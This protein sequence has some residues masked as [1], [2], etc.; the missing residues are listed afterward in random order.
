MKKNKQNTNLKALPVL[1]V[2][3]IMGFCDIVGISSDYVQR[4]FNWS[5]AMTGFVPSMVFLWFLFLGIPV[6]NWMNT[7]GRKNTVLVSMVLTM[8]GMALPLV[9]YDSM[10]CMAAYALLG[11]GNAILQVSLN[12]LLSN[13]IT[14]KKLITSS[15]TAGQVIKAVSSLV[16][17]EIVLLAVHYWGIDKWYYCF[18]ILGFMT[19][20]SAVWLLITPIEREKMVGQR[21][22]LSMRDT[23]TLLGNRT[24]LLLFLGIFFIVGVDV[25]VNFISSKLMSMRFGWTA[26][27]VKYAPQ[28]YFLCRTI[29]AFIGTFLLTRIAE[30]KYFRANILMCV[31]VLLLLMFI[32]DSVVDILC[33]GAIGFFGSSVFSIIYSMALQARPDK[34][35]QISGLMITAIAGGGVVSPIIGFAMGKM[36]VIG[37]VGVILLCVLYLTYCAFGIE[38]KTCQ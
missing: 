22:G 26:E 2:F 18:P 20:L 31:V 36:G 10:T 9:V 8:L 29:G 30:I 28:A 14:N 35:N 13:V 3:F 17:P 5:S 7:W 21:D 33:I 16:G 38:I 12:P 37:G 11:I 15:L 25:A 19:L 27:Q 1:F 6:G 4:H 23:F 24:I 34:A 32:D